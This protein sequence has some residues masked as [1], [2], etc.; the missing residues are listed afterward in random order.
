MHS[1]LNEHLVRNH[2]LISH[3]D[4]YF[5]YP[6]VELFLFQFQRVLLHDDVGVQNIEVGDAGEP[7]LFALLLLGSLF[8][9]FQAVVDLLFD[10]ILDRHNLLLR[11]SD[12][13]EAY[14]S[15][16]FLVDLELIKPFLVFLFK[17]L[18]PHTIEQ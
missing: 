7:F 17:F 18:I 4:G 12:H 15:N 13:F 16:R 5:V 1:Y 11:L 8:T 3:F 9:L 14:R 2:R 6:L 10:R